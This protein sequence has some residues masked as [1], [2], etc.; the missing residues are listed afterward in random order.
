[1]Q[2]NPYRYI[3]PLDPVKDGVVCLSRAKDI[4]RL[5]NGI[6]RGDYWAVQGP[7]RSGKT[8]L[9]NQ[10]KHQFP[11]SRYLVKKDRVGIETKIVRVGNF[12]ASGVI[13]RQRRLEPTGHG[14][15]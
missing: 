9:L 14:I 11:G 8:T 6:N 1:M 7:G 3:G 10:L 13:K 15:G 2:Q 4:K 5:I 12:V